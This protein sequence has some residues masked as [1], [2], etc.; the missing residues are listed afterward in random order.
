MA[1]TLSG[2]KSYA[3]L[4][5][6]SITSK[7]NVPSDDVIT[8]H[9]NLCK[10]IVSSI[11][12]IPKTDPLPESDANT[13]ATYFLCN[14]YL[15]T[16]SVLNRNTEV[17]I[18]MISENQVLNYRESLLPSVMRALTGM[19]CRDRDVSAFMPEVQT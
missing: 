3:G 10:K 16:R 14:F 8:L 6:G 7:L 9:L 11:L 17:S 15:Q 5:P 4:G 12:G 19:V 1:V 18:D 2:F 13:V